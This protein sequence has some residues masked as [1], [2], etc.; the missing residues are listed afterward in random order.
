MKQGNTDTTQ[1]IAT[2]AAQ[3]AARFKRRPT[4][5]DALEA[6][7]AVVLLQ[8]RQYAQAPVGSSKAAYV[9]QSMAAAAR[10]YDQAACVFRDGGELPTG[11]PRGRSLEKA[12]VRLLR[13][14]ETARKR[15]AGQRADRKKARKARARSVRA[16]A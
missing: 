3:W 1:D 8:A 9:L 14:R 11:R 16:K 4:A 13:D 6:T 7:A 2:H 10:M 15:A 5:K 12:A